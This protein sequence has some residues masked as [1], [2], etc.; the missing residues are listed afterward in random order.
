MKARCDQRAIFFGSSFSLFNAILPE[1][2]TLWPGNPH[3]ALS[4]FS[5]LSDFVNFDEKIKP[6]IYGFY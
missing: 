1:C 2:A 5:G 6:V 4:G 3:S